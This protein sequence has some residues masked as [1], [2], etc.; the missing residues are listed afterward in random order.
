MTQ[1]LHRIGGGLVARQKEALAG[2]CA[3]R[4]CQLDANGF[5]QTRSDPA[6]ALCPEHAVEAKFNGYTIYHKPFA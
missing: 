4:N 1:N 6:F 3:V 5:V 2:W